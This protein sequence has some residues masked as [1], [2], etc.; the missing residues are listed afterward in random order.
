MKR[1]HVFYATILTLA[2]LVN[3]SSIQAAERLSVLLVDGQ[4]NHQWQQ[5]TPVIKRILENAGIFEVTVSTAPPGPP[6]KPRY[7][8][9]KKVSDEQKANYATQ[10]DEWKKKTLEV[11]QNSDKM[12][13]AW[14]P[15]FSDYNVVLSNYNGEAWPEDV[16]KSFEEYVSNGGGFVCLHA[17]DNSFTGWEEYNKMIAVGG[18][19]G[20][21]E[22]H[23]PMLRLRD[24]KWTRDESKGNGGTHGQ[25]LPVDIM[26]RNSDHPIVKGLPKEFK[27]P[28]DEVYG[29]LR[30][31]AKNVEILAT[32]W[33]DPNTRGTGEHEPIM[34]VINYGKGRVFHNTLG[35]DIISLTGVGFQISLQRGTEWA[36]TGKVAQELPM[37]K[38]GT[39]SPTV[40][41]P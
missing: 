30:G 15:K 38:L 41:E 10:L 26:I 19:G 2:C 24:G 20:R 6:K 5:T 25:R 11:K 4:N 1:S 22:T 37:V 9:G 28:A 36:A 35:H 7:P 12:W 17:A 27:H 40:M 21:N 39:E 34:M 18:W 16:Q 32:A 29:K 13:K 14:K 31:P 3:F 33:S 23:G 8:R